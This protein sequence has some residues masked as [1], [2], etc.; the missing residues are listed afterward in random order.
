MYW[1]SSDTHFSHKNIM[2]YCRRPFATVEEMDKT[3]LNNLEDCVKP[4]DTLYFLGDLTF[5]IE[6]A[7]IFFDLMKGV[8]IHFIIGNHDKKQVLKYARDHSAS[9]LHMKD[10]KIEDQNITL[11]H[12]SMRVWNKS[13]FDSQMLYGHSHGGL[14]PVGKQWD[15]GVDN[16]NF[17]PLSFPEIQEIMEDRPH[18]FN[19]LAMEERSR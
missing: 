17:M 16:N 3:I 11:N 12:Y 7:K 2:K 19:Y 8:E 14:D 10:I 15:V 6:S 13:H 1:F 5:K 4:G 18:N 9:C